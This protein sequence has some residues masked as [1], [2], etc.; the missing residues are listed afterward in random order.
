MCRSLSCR[1]N[2]GRIEI[3][4]ILRNGEF[5]YSR[6][7][8]QNFLHNKKRGGTFIPRSPD[9]SRHVVLLRNLKTRTTVITVAAITT[10]ARI[11]K[12]AG[13]LEEESDVATCMTKQINAANA[14]MVPKN[15]LAFRF[16][17]RNACCLGLY[18][19]FMLLNPP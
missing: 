2:R 10:N 5:Q 6:S 12:P 13:I 3:I 4:Y 16:Q 19:S 11:P 15:P 8:F 14:T 1:G 18:F 7:F 17:E 9:C